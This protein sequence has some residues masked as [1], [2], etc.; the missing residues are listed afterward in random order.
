MGQTDMLSN[1]K[2]DW[3]RKKQVLVAWLDLWDKDLLGPK[4]VRSIKHTSVKFSHTRFLQ[5]IL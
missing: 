2:L 5:I 1:K 4:R 3:E